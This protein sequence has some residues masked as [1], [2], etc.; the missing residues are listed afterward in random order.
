MVATVGLV[1][2]RPHPDHVARVTTPPY[3]VIKDGSGLRRR[4]SA[5]PDSIFHVILGDAPVEALDG[6]R[7]RGAVVSD[8]EPAYY[9]Y[10]Q[11]FG[12]ETRTGVFVAAEVTDYAEQQI[13]RHEKTFD[14]KVKGRI[15]LANATGH[16]LGPV[17]LLTKAKLSDVLERAKAEAPVYAFESDFGG[18]TDLD[19][20][21]NRVWRVPQDGA[22]GAA[23]REA[24]GPHPLYIA[25]G[26]HRYHAALRNGQTH[27][28]AYVTEEARIL[29][30]DRVVNGVVPFAEAKERLALTEAPR[31]ETPAKHEFCLYTKDGCWTLRAQEVPTDVVGRLDCAILERELYPHLGLT[32]DHIVD[33]KHFDYYPESALDEMRAVVDDGT[34]ELA[35]ALA[36]VSIDELMAVADAGLEDPDVVMP[37]KSTFFSPKILTG[38][39]LYRHTRR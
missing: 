7:E 8:D 17:F 33:P 12:D 27:L 14:E 23:I 32:H 19:G 34:Y 31:F 35:I 18:G 39:F 29:A 10:E 11:R 22:V 28:L 6:L 2:L 20:I 25:D 13:I 3:D 38:L 16:T 9:V 15:A 4:L 1:G 26:H 21:A 36:P 24:L 37:E 5:N 30:Y